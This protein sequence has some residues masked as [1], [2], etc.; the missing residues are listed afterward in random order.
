MVGEDVEGELGAAE[1]LAFY[2]VVGLGVMVSD[3]GQDWMMK[4]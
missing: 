4:G 1:L 3:T 2:W